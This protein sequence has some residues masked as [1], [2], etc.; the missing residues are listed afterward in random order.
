MWIFQI[1]LEKWNNKWVLPKFF[2]WW[3]LL[4]HQAWLAGAMVTHMD[5]ASCLSVFLCSF[6]L[7]SC[8]DRNDALPVSVLTYCMH[9][10]KTSELCFYSQMQQKQCWCNVRKQPNTQW[11]TVGIQNVFALKPL[12][13]TKIIWNFTNNGWI[14]MQSALLILTASHNKTVRLLCVIFGEHPVNCSQ[15]S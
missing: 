1:K 4:T 5:W 12:L 13:V 2:L 9:L 8:W 11:I 15:S 6:L 7:W 14:L 3:M 10:C